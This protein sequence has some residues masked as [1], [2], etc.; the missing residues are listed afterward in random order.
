M[1]VGGSLAVLAL[2]IPL[3]SCVAAV[4]PMVAA[5]LV[6]R[7]ATG[8]PVDSAPSVPIDT[9]ATNRTPI[10]DKPLSASPLSIPTTAR[11]ASSTSRPEPRS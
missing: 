5:G 2:A 6:G 4:A 8:G 11:R 9:A 1:R 3:G 10:L 7:A